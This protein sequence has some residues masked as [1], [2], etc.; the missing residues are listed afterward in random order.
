MHNW[1]A[2][3]TD[4]VSPAEETP[5][6]GAAA[7]AK[8]EIHEQYEGRKTVAVLCWI[9]GLLLFLVVLWL[10]WRGWRTGVKGIVPAL[11]DVGLVG[12]LP[13]VA[14]FFLGKWLLRR[15]VEAEVEEEQFQRETDFMQYFLR[16]GRVTFR[17]MRED[18]RFKDD[19]V[20]G[21]LIDLAGKRLFRGYIDWRNEEIVSIGEVEISD[22]CPGCESPL[23]HIDATIAVCDNC[24]LQA[25]K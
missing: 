22:D 6:K 5:S 17:E 18:F 24:G 15:S 21:F 12:V 8:E 25:F 20:R 23:N 16:K 7:A 10:N 11:R 9:A 19:E 13:A 2:D 14:L 4:E 3:P 1:K